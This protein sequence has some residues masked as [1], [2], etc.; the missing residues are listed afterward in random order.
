[1]PACSSAS[2][3]TLTDHDDGGDDLIDVFGFAVDDHARVL[4][5]IISL[6]EGWR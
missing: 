5:V 6:Q 1:M 4:G 3:R 2:G